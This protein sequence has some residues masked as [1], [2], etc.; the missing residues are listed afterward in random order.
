MIY[1]IISMLSPHPSGLCHH[2]LVRFPYPKS[3]KIS[4]FDMPLPTGDIT[5]RGMEHSGPRDYSGSSSISV[6]KILDCTQQPFMVVAEEL[7]RPVFPISGLRPNLAIPSG[8]IKGKPGIR[9]TLFAS[10]NPD[11]N[12]S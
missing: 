9:S 6:S 4:G 3:A 1:S 7:F 10:E 8:E 11:H 5:H 12:P 2:K